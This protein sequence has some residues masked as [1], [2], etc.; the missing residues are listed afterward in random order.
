LILNYNKRLAELEA[1][2]S[3]A[4][5]A[6]PGEIGTWA[7]PYSGENTLQIPFRA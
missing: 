4:A 6:Q 3:D 1:P 2:N 7:K 5:G